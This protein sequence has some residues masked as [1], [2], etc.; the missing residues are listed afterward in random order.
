MYK[1]G[2]QVSIDDSSVVPIRNVGRLFRVSLFHS[3]TEDRCSG[4]YRPHRMSEL[5]YLVTQLRFSSYD[6]FPNQYH[7]LACAFGAL[8]KLGGEIMGWIHE[9]QRSI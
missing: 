1:S 5:F 8:T 2:K 3:I 4:S 7:T 9:Q 6:S